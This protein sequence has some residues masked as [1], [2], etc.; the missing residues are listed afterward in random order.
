MNRFVRRALF[1]GDLIPWQRAIL[2]WCGCRTGSRRGDLLALFR[3]G[4]QIFNAYP[5]LY[6]RKTSDFG[7][8]LLAMTAADSVTGPKGYT[9]LGQKRCETMACSALPMSRASAKRAAFRAW[10]TLPGP[11]WLAMGRL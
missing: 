5:V 8:P 1:Q 9:Q 3:S 7:P 10:I 11:Q 2:P 4:L 6:R